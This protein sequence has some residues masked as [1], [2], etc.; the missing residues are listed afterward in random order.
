MIEGTADLATEKMVDTDMMDTGQMGKNCGPEKTKIQVKITNF[1]KLI[2]D[3][4]GKWTEVRRNLVVRDGGGGRNGGGCVEKDGMD[5]PKALSKRRKSR[6]DPTSIKRDS[7]K[8]KKGARSKAGKGPRKMNVCSDSSQRGI[9]EFFG[10]AGQGNNGNWT[11]F[12]REIPKGFTDSHKTRPKEG[13]FV[14]FLLI[15]LKICCDQD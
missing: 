14:C 12:K 9:G 8:F 5:Q 10:V 11:S 15:A 6:N 2:P 3:F 4:R 1:T 7:G 13:K